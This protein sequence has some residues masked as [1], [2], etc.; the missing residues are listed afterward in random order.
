MARED[1]STTNATRGES[2][3]RSLCH[4]S[5]AAFTRHVLPTSATFALL[6]LFDGGQESVDLLGADFFDLWDV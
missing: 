2:S 3:H 5:S 4:G 6:G 1:T